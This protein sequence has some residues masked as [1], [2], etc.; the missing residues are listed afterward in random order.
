VLNAFYIG[1]AAHTS[2]HNL[3]ANQQE[4][5]NS[6][7]CYHAISKCDI[8]AGLLVIIR[9]APPQHGFRKY[10]S[11]LSRPNIPLENCNLLMQ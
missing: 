6:H 11:I 4:F 7:S 9:D 3:E 5:F 2:V 8:R 10:F 1:V